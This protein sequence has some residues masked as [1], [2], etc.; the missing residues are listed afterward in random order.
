MEVR[1]FFDVSRFATVFVFVVLFVSVRLFMSGERYSCGRACAGY[2]CG[3]ACAEYRCMCR[4]A[5]WP[6]L[7]TT[8]VTGRRRWTG[9]VGPRFGKRHTSQARASAVPA[10]SCS[11]VALVTYVTSGP[12]FL[13]TLTAHT[14]FISNLRSDNHIGILD[15][16][17][18]ETIC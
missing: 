15:V 4:V 3:R 16:L 6:N 1:W 9:D 11:D 7:Q 14:F 8:P 12:T 18:T 13:K 10:F 5:G 17:L 2:S